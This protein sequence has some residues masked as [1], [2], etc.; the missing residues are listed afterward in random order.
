MQNTLNFYRNETILKQGDVTSSL[1]C[2]KYWITAVLKLQLGKS[3]NFNNNPLTC[4]CILKFEF[5]I[6]KILNL[7]LI[8]LPKAKNSYDLRH[9]KICFSDMTKQRC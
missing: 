8:Q 3:T 6:F 1:Y 9:R 2:L 4:T 5:K 7:T